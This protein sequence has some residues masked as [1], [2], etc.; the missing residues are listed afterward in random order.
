MTSEEGR[1]TGI[2]PGVLFGSRRDAQELTDNLPRQ[3]RASGSGGPRART[4]SPSPVS[5]EFPS[6]MASLGGAGTTMAV[7][8]LSRSMATIGRSA[9]AVRSGRAMPSQPCLVNQSADLNLTMAC[10]NHPVETNAAGVPRQLSGQVFGY[11]RQ[12]QASVQV[13]TPLMQCRLA[14]RRRASLPGPVATESS[15]TSSLSS[16]KVSANSHSFVAPTGGSEEKHGAAS[17][18]SFHSNGYGFVVSPTHRQSAAPQVQQP[19]IP[20]GVA[21]VGAMPSRAATQQRPQVIRASAVPWSQVRHST[22]F[23]QVRRPAPAA[24]PAALT[25]VVAARQT[26]QRQVRV[27]GQD[28]LGST[29]R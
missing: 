18:R 29:W 7:D 11:P 22:Q 24:A 6:G 27:H 4:L 9:G 3:H 16:I 14:A 8:P 12:S 26:Y 20:Q 15:P 1:S 28:L 13:T 10:D 23:Q 17:S 5:P 19:Q 2:N 21:T 25:Q